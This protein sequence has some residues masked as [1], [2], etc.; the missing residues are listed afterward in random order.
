MD[1]FL[2]RRLLRDDNRG[3]GHGVTDNREILST[4]KLLFE[5][6]H[7][8]CEWTLP[9]ES[10]TIDLG[11][12]SNFTDGLPDASRASSIHGTSL[13]AAHVPIEIGPGALP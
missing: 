7:T 11:R 6:R 12:R 1:V 8:V 4:F 13:P 9:I 5:A 3:L 2:D 10:L